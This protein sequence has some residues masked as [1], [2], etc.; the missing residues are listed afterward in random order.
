MDAGL[1]VAIVIGAILLIAIFALLGKKSAN[2]RDEQRRAE[3][4][5]H[6]DEARV[7][8]ARATKAEA[9]AEE[10]QARAK[11]EEAIAQEQAAVA[12]RERR[13]A[14]S[15]EERAADLDPDRDPERDPVRPQQTRTD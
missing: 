4:R 1:I 8:S 3:A 14:R 10:R 5:T 6:R 2:R 15:K 9:E 11:R 7:R 12:E 13:F